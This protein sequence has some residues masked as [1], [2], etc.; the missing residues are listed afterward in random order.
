ML[1]KQT[2]RKEKYFCI[3]CNRSFGSKKVFQRDQKE[4]QEANDNVRFYL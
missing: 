2:K 1:I 4:H 3:K